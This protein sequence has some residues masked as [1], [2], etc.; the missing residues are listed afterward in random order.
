MFSG[1]SDVSLGVAVFAPPDVSSVMVSPDVRVRRRPRRPL[2]LPPP[3]PPVELNENW[4][5]SPGTLVSVRPLPTLRARKET[6]GS[7]GG[8]VVPG[9]TVASFPNLIVTAV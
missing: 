4:R 7:G 3:P 1:T 9:S 6:V 2:G 8:G 5:V